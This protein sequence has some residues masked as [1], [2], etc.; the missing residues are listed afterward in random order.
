[1]AMGSMT[2]TSNLR[3]ACTLEHMLHMYGMPF[4]QDRSGARSEQSYIMKLR[5]AV[6][7]AQT[8]WHN[9]RMWAQ[10]LPQSLPHT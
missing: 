9:K 5:V 10:I 2:V 1:M 7:Q 4:E 8:P 3:L 6:R